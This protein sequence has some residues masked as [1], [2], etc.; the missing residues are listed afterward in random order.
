MRYYDPTRLP[1]INFY[2]SWIPVFTSLGGWQCRTLLKW[3]GWY[4][5]N[6]SGPTEEALNDPDNQD[7]VNAYYTITRELDK[8]FEKWEAYCDKKNDE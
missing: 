6:N 1:S 7:L 5:F 2:P 3:I 8:Q 4:A